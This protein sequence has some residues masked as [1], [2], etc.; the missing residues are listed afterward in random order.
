LALALLTE[1]ATG[2]TISSSQESVKPGK[3]MRILIKR[4][5]PTGYQDVI[6][7]DV[8]GPDGTALSYLSSNLVI[9]NEAIPTIPIASNQPAG[10]YQVQA[11]PTI[12]TTAAELFFRVEAP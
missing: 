2:L 11:R 5:S 7:I 8:F 12:G 4:P 9:Q 3:A 6:H 1:K 10:K